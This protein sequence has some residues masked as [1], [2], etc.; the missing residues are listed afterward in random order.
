MSS[1]K[2]QVSNTTCF[3][4]FSILYLASSLSTGGMMNIYDKIMLKTRRVLVSTCVCLLMYACTCSANVCRT[5]NF[6]FI[7]CLQPTLNITNS[8]F[9]MCRY[10][11]YF[12]YHYFMCHCFLWLITPLSKSSL[13]LL[14]WHCWLHYLHC[15]LIEVLLTVKCK[16]KHSTHNNMFYWHAILSAYII[17]YSNGRE[18]FLQG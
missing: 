1:S 10:L 16:C 14:C 3:E 2:Y 15:R 18:W 9:S 13:L 12:Y 6:I 11:I 5:S 17:L 4:T 7:M 8:T